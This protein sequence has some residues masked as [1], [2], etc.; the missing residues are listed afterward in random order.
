[1]IILQVENWSEISKKCWALRAS[2]H[3]QNRWK[4]YI[5]QGAFSWNRD[6]SEECCSSGTWNHLAWWIF[7][8]VFARTY[9]HTFTSTSNHPCTHIWQEQVSLDTFR[10][11]VKYCMLHIPEYSIL[12]SYHPEDLKTHTNASLSMNGVEICPRLLWHG[13]ICSEFQQNWF[14]HHSIA[15]LVTLLSLHLNVWQMWHDFCHL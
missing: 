4:C 5:D 15:C 12:H 8:N 13:L 11:S 7:T 3:Q 10:K 14:L 1:M 2:I 9:C 6:V